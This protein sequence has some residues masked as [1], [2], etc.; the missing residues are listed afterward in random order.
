[1]IRTDIEMFLLVK[2]NSTNSFP[3]CRVLFIIN[4]IVSIVPLIQVQELEMAKYNKNILE[5]RVVWNASTHFINQKW[6]ISRPWVAINFY[7]IRCNH[8]WWKLWKGYNV[9]SKYL[10]NVYYICGNVLASRIL[11]VNRIFSK[12]VLVM[13]F[14]I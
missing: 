12:A 8:M 13:Q 10:L 3:K 9:L 4:S 2:I 1:M 11:W 5:N 14:I 6:K 7:L